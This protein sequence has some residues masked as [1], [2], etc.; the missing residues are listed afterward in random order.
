[1]ENVVLTVK[2][3]LFLVMG[4]LVVG[5]AGTALIAGLCQMARDS[6][7]RRR[8]TPAGRSHLPTRAG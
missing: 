2:F 4:F 3:V 5:M 8:W 1:M 6:I 7:H